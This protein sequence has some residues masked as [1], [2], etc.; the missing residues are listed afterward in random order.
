[1]PAV[2]WN[3]PWT[4]QKQPPAM[5]AVW[6]PLA[7]VASAAGAGMITASSAAREGA[8]ANAAMASA[9]MAAAHSERRLNWRGDMVSSGARVGGSLER[10]RCFAIGGDPCC[11]QDTRL[12][13]FCYGPPHTSS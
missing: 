10:E 1:T 9:P 7:A 8:T 3:T 2:C 13:R 12:G 6:M 4:P 11:P 5:T